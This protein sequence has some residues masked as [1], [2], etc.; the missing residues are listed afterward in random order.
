MLKCCDNPVIR[1]S[2]ST[3]L[4]WEQNGYKACYLNSLIQPSVT[5]F[6]AAMSQINGLC[7]SLCA[8]EFVQTVH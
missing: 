7:F 3:Q 2:I 1:A 4:Y 8:Q 6:D 5:S